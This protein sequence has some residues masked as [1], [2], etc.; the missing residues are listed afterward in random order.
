MKTPGFWYRPAGATARLLAP[1]GWL[2]G[3]AG[4]LRGRVTTP[5][6]VGIPVA[7][8]GNLVAGG[9][10]KTPVALALGAVMAGLPSPGPTVHFVTR[11]YGGRLRGP[12]AV[13]ASVHDAAAVGD[14]A[15]LLAEAA[16]TW[17]S[18]DRVAGAR[19]AVAAGASAIVL[20]DGFQNPCLHK[21]VSL[22]VVDGGAGTGNG[23][24]VPAGPLRE[25]VGRGLARADAVVILGEDRMGVEAKVAGRRPVLHAR[26]VPDATACELDGRRVVAFAG[27]ARP[28]KFFGTLEELGAVIVEAVPFP[29]HHP[30]Q[31]IELSRLAGLAERHGAELVTT[32]KDA[33][34]LPPELRALVRT[35]RVAVAWRDPGALERVLAPLVRKAKSTAGHGA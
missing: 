9:A 12:L 18:A 10:G 30:F 25:P 35:V 14:E 20:D 16:P 7:C 28:A 13:D 4:W 34:R 1:A 6:R 11:G 26:L 22:V 27:L 29:D 8:V 24:L 17:V 32:A 19:A 23:C 5:V 15:L 2:Y 21:D 31:P 33:V 3:A